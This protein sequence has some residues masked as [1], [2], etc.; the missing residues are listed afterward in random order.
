MAVE[1]QHE[2]RGESI[3]PERGPQPGEC[4]VGDAVA[5]IGHR[6]VG[7]DGDVEVHGR[8]GARS[9]QGGGRGVDAAVGAILATGMST[10]LTIPGCLQ[11][12]RRDHQRILSAILDG[13]AA[14]AR[15]AAKRHVTA[16]RDAALLR[17][18]GEK[19]EPA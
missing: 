8:G 9:G 14:A 7:F 4:L 13:D 18:A 3:H 16:A 6:G 2:L 11:R 1:T 17:L 19:Q 15:R 12:S 5:E 10:T